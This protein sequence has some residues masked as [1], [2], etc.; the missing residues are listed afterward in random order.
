MER[1]GSPTRSSTNVAMEDD[2]SLVDGYVEAAQRE[3]L[4]RIIDEME[5]SEQEFDDYVMV[6]IFRRPDLTLKIELTSET[7][8]FFVYWC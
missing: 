3:L 4:M 5:S 2:P 6:R 8:V 7:N 1:K